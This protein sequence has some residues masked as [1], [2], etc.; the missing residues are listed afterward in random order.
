MKS[1]FPFQMPKFYCD[2]CDIFLTHDSMR[3]RNDH[4]AGWKHKM[5]LQN[6]W[7]N[8]DARRVQVVVDRITQAYWEAGL[9][10]FPELVPLGRGGNRKQIRPQVPAGMPGMPGM[11]PLPPGM[12]PPPGMLP[13][14]PPGMLP[15]PPGFHGMP[16]PFPPGF[17]PPPPGFIPPAT[18]RT[19]TNTVDPSSKKL[20]Q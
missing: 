15:P 1:K 5:F 11:P 7:T 13:G 12:M 14:M 16:R 10:G 2:Y 3:V 19:S 20:K 17:R 6:Y 9:P 4:N 8:L 18:K